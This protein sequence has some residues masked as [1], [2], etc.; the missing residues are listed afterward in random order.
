MK[1]YAAAL[2]FGLIGFA[3]GLLAE[4]RFAEQAAR[5]DWIAP[6][7]MTGFAGGTGAGIDGAAGRPFKLGIAG[8]VIGA[9]IGVV[10]DAVDGGPLSAIV[11]SAVLI[12]GLASFGAPAETDP[13]GRFPPRR[14]IF[15][16]ISI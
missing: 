1:R 6:V 8:G 12:I 9:V 13:E 3:L 4:L 10:L 16:A 5:L 14:V 11:F 15:F 2:V 7:A